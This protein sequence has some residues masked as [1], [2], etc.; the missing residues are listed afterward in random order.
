[1]AAGQKHR[2]RR[3]PD[4]ADQG[5]AALRGRVG[6]AHPGSVRS[7]DACSA[8]SGARLGERHPLRILVADDNVVNQKVARSMLE[9]LGY[10]AD[11]VANGLEAVDAVRRM[12]YDVVLTDL[13]M[14]ELEGLGAM[15]QIR[16]D[17]PEGRRP[18]IVA[19]TANTIEE[20]GEESLAAGMD[21]YLSKPLKKD[22]LEAALGR[23][24][25][26]EALAPQEAARPR[27]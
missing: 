27:R 4:Q 21:D 19:L 16:S 15:R 11:L 24:R 22:K 20:D 12:P 9:R 8:P 3:V 25:R 6:C 2:S 14:P 23:A 7:P 13:Q 5:V 1:M 10:R 18:R 17:H 26:L